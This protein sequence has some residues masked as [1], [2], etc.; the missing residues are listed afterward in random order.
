MQMQKFVLLSMAVFWSNICLGQTSMRGLLY[1]DSFLSMPRV[2]K[3]SKELERVEGFLNRDLVPNLGSMERAGLQSSSDQP[4]RQMK[5]WVSEISTADAHLRTEVSSISKSVK[6]LEEV[7]G[8]CAI[9]L[10]N[11]YE[12]KLADRAKNLYS[13]MTEV[14]LT[15]RSTLPKPQF[16]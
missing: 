10:K 12:M 3:L 6:I 2:Q 13:R 14:C 7:G 4:C 9:E 15:D 1:C 5:A 8:E 16:N 11:I